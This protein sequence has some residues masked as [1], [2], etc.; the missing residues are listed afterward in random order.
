MY[1]TSKEIHMHMLRCMLAFF[2]MGMYP[3]TSLAAP[4]LSLCCAVQ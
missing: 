2:L 1:T 3:K 4:A